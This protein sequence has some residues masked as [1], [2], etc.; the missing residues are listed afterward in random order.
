MELKD[1]I[2][3]LLI[4]LTGIEGK[5]YAVYAPDEAWWEAR[6]YSRIN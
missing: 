5:D 1:L 2:F 3:T 4:M 6:L